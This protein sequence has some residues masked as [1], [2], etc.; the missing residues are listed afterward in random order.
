M[1]AKYQ[2]GTLPEAERAASKSKGSR[3][4]DGHGGSVLSYL[5]P[6]AVLA[7]A[8]WY[9]FLGGAAVIKKQTSGA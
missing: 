3:G 1:L 5:V 7:F 9:Q 2:I 8:V 6:I 4:D